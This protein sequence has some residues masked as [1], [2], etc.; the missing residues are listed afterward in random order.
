MKTKKIDVDA[1]DAG[2]DGIFRYKAVLAGANAGITGTYL[3]FPLDAAKVRLQT[4]HKTGQHYSGTQ[5]VLRDLWREG[6]MRAMFKGVLAPVTSLSILFAVNFGTYDFTRRKLAKWVGGENVLV[7]STAGAVAGMVSGIINTPFDIIKVKSQID[8]INKQKYPNSIAVGRHQI[9]K[10]GAISLFRGFPTQLAR[11]TVFGF[12]YFGLYHTTRDYITT[13]SQNWLG[14]QYWSAAGIPMAGAIAGTGAWVMVYPIDIVKT[15]LQI[16]PGSDR[17]RAT[18]IAK[19]IWNTKGV[20]GFFPG[21]SACL[22]RAFFV[23]AARF[24]TYEVTMY[25]CSRLHDYLAKRR[26]EKE[27]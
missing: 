23:H 6:G 15:N 24:S 9:Q 16:R 5:H 19:K 12:F 25:A 27:L 17:T 3:G 8:N 26:A 1:I 4:A 11:E 14:S 21:L 10:Y 2:Y 20:S 13:R 7:H 22:T 18:T